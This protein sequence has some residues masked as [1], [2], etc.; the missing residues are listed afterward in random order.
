[1]G[2][3]PL[4]SFYFFLHLFIHFICCVGRVESKRLLCSKPKH[5]HEIKAGD[6]LAAP[7]AFANWNMG[8]MLVEDLEENVRDVDFEIEQDGEFSGF[9]FWFDVSFKGSSPE[10]EV[11]LSTGPHAPLTHW[12]QGLLLLDEPTNL[13]K[14]D[15]LRGRI[16]VRRN[17]IWRRHYNITV[18]LPASERIPKE[19][20]RMFLMWR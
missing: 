13:L 2:R 7:M 20:N 6:M 10:N 18:T 1:M 12:K 16:A 5:D 15:R 9:G 8:D 3:P 4:W 14:G 17:K 19:I 11:T